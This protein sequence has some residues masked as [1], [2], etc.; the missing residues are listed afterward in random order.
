[1]VKV[2]GVD[3]FV[4]NNKGDGMEGDVDDNKVNVDDDDDS[5]EITMV[6]VTVV[7]AEMDKQFEL[8]AYS[9]LRWQAFTARLQL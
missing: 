1:M 5:G 8:Q 4:G 7:I 9:S 3:N 6:K 2:F